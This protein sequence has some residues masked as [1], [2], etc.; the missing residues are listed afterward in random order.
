MQT[1]GRIAAVWVGRLERNLAAE[2][3][4]LAPLISSPNAFKYLCASSQASIAEHVSYFVEHDS[5]SVNMGLLKSSKKAAEALGTRDVMSTE[6]PPPAY[7]AEKIPSV[8]TTAA[9]AHIIIPA[10]ETNLTV[11]SCLVHLKLLHAFSV[12]K[13]DVGYTD[14]LFGLWDNWVEGANIDL[15]QDSIPATSDDAEQKML[16]LSKIREK[17]WAL[18]VARAV[19][20]YE[21]WWRSLKGNPLHEA[22]MT[23]ADS[24]KFMNFSKSQ[25]RMNWT[26]RQL[27]PLGNFTI[28]ASFLIRYGC[29]Y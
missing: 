15:P 1:F 17:R 21:S 25:E 6:D 2:G 18:F 19:V 10:I 20:R 14:G 4:Y 8:D 29:R 9:F 5:T 28:I 12:L 24:P 11:E 27:P 26:E 23:N 7:D 3:I 16:T 13:E 22:D